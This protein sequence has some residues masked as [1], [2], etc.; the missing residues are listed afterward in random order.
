MTM[1]GELSFANAR[2]RLTLDEIESAP[3]NPA[4]FI[5]WP[6]EGE[7]YL[8]R[9][10]LLRRRLTRLLK[11]RERP[12][13]LLNLRHVTDHV[14]YWLVGSRLELGHGWS[15][16]VCSCAGSQRGQP[17]SG[18]VVVHREQNPW[19]QVVRVGQV[20]QGRARSLGWWTPS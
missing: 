2:R 19:V 9:T 17:V 20:R 5:V 12:S 3:N 15:T 18:W 7:P 14:D 13:R 16:G 8:G 1:Q 4:V 10:G 11:D 6:R